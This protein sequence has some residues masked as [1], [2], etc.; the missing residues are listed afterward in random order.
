MATSKLKLPYRI[1]EATVT[2]SSSKHG[3]F[4]Y[5]DVAG[6][7]RASDVLMACTISTDSNKF[8]TAQI[9]TNVVRVFSDAQSASVGVRL[10]LKN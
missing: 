9:L 8:S 3:S 7:Y 1:F 4:Y 10:F 2:T 6:D 5:A